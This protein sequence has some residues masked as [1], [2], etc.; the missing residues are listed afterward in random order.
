[1]NRYRNPIKMA[2]LHS[3]RERRLVAY[4][5]KDHTPGRFCVGWFVRFDDEDAVFL[6]V[7]QEVFT[8]VEVPVPVDE[9]EWIRTDTPYLRGLEQIW[10]TGD[11]YNADASGE[12]YSE[13][14]YIETVLKEAFEAGH[15]VEMRHR[16]DVSPALV[17]VLELDEE[18]ACLQDLLEDDA[19][20]F[21]VRWCRVR[22]I[23]TVHK[24]SAK[25]LKME[26]LLG[27]PRRFEHPAER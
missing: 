23:A 9:L 21:G 8:G 6:D 1:M 16:Q 7:P 26:L 24:D 5:R 27:M 25:C 17:Q 13:F 15:V 20:S 2:L 14:E 18:F 19:S 22:E 4:G 10:L 12:T 11:P 3:A